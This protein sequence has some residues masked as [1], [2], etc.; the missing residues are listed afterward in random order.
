MILIITTLICLNYFV[1]SPSCVAS[2]GVSLVVYSILSLVILTTIPSWEVVS[3]TVVIYVFSVAINAFLM[4]VA[5]SSVDI[6][7]VGV[8][9][10][11]VT[12][13]FIVVVW[14]VVVVAF[15]NSVV[16]GV[17]VGVVVVEV[18]EGVVTVV[19]VAVLI[20]TYLTNKSLENIYQTNIFIQL[21]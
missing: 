20:V 1:P 18:V 4:V 13:A 9:I 7:V 11:V 14:L 10:S 12:G 6:C 2:D 15:A 19:D 16:V 17:V 3:V 8:T 5:V 21:L